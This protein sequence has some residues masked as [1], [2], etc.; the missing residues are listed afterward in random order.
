MKP[1]LLPVLL[2]GLCIALPCSAE[3]LLIERAQKAQHTATPARGSSMDAVRA[4]Y[5]E[6]KSV[7]GPVGQPPITRWDYP[8]FAVYFEHQHVI[9]S[10]LHKSHELEMGPRRVAQPAH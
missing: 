4:L 10:V 6:P 1:L 8:A 9:N 3:T 2:V 7:H 5:G